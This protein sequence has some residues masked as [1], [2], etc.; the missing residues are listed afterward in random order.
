MK[1]IILTLDVGTGSVR[2]GLVSYL[3]EIIGFSQQEYDQITPQSGWSEQAPSLW[4]QGALTGISQLLRTYPE[5]KDRIAVVASCGQMHGTVLIDAQGELVIDRALLWNDKRNEAQVKQFCEQHNTVA[6]LTRLNNPPTTAWPAFK[7]AWIQQFMPEEWRKTAYILMPKD[8]I[9]FM[10]TGEIATDYSEA[11]CFYL[12]DS[13]SKKYDPEIVALFGIN[14]SQLPP[15]YQA[16]DIIGTVTASI[17]AMTGLPQGIPVVA[18]TADMAATLL[19]SGVYERGTASDS[20]GTST[21]LTV[22]SDRPVISSRLNNLHLANNAW[23]GF[24]ILDAGGDAMRWARLAFHDNQRSYQSM[25]E[26]ARAVQFGSESLFFLPY[27][28]GERNAEKNNSRAQF[29]G[30]NRKH[31]AGH[32]YRAILE[33]VGFAAAMNLRQLEQRSIPIESVIASGGGAK[34]EL[35]LSIKAAIYNKPIIKTKAE[36]NGTLGCAMIGA[37]GVGLFQDEKQAV[38]KVIAVEKEIMPDPRQVDYYQQASVVFEQL[39]Q[40][41]QALYDQL[42]TLNQ[43]AQEKV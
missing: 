30:L 4:W 12:M 39:Y 18:G 36:E 1:D 10:L 24:S 3:G 34:D 17:C 40:Q 26:A 7:I 11:S 31:R 16:K 28:T 37:L 33:G 9:N 5:Y 42:D 22:V 13:L 35:W 15:I 41:S 20:T 38:S 21:L 27:L 6:L 19:G 32:L 8:Y 2:A 23:G 43:L 14:P 25:I 29:F